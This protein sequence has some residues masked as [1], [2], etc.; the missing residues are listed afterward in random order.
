MSMNDRYVI[1]I[2]IITGQG[3]AAA[4]AM[5]GVNTCEEMCMQREI[6]ISYKNINVRFWGLRPEQ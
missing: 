1:R 5:V 3:S 6:Y 4:A 2:I